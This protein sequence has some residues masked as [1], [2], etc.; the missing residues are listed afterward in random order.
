MALTFV[1]LLFQLNVSYPPQGSQ[2][3][4]EI[5]DEKKVRVFYEKRIGATVDMDSIGDEWKGYVCRITGG[6]DKQGF[7]MKQGVLTT[8]E[9]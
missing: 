6:N 1:K 3:L 8:S 5:D 4:F 2:K 7:P 9:Y